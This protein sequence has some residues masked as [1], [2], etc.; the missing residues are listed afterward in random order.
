MISGRSRA[1][2]ARSAATKR[3]M[4]REARSATL[5]RR[6][7]PQPVRKDGRLATPYGPPRDD[8]S[9]RTHHALAVWRRRRGIRIRRRSAEEVHDG[10]TGAPEAWLANPRQVAIEQVHRRIV[11]RE[12]ELVGLDEP[13]IDRLAKFGASDVERGSLAQRVFR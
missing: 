1:V 6:V 9:T 10:V 12:V 11:E 2:I 7:G 4:E 8:D 5:D 3:S 13:P